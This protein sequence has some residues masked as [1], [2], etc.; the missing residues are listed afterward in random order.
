MRKRR[1][2]EKEKE[3]HGR[4]GQREKE[5]RDR[6]KRKGEKEKRKREREREREACAKWSK[7]KPESGNT[8]RGPPQ[9]IAGRPAP[10]LKTGIGLPAPVSNWQTWA[11]RQHTAHWWRAVR[12]EKRERWPKQR[13]MSCEKVRTT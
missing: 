1:D 5:R 3:K 4:N 8:V 7:A 9:Q 2:R 6:E 11:R 10:V 13:N 12:G